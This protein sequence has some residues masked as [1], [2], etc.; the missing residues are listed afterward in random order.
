MRC[1]LCKESELTRREVSHVAD[2]DGIEFRGTIEADACPACG[3]ELASHDE[4]R[5]FDLHVADIL[6]QRAE[7]KPER[8]RFIRRALGFKGVELAR[9]LDVTPETVSRWENVSSDREMD[10][11]SFAL[12]GAMVTDAIAGRDDT[13][14]RL[15]GAMVGPS[16]VEPLRSPVRVQRSVA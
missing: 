11:R 7:R 4:L 12:L 15:E 14:R 3:E 1:P 6:A 8:V 16:K 5:R 13:R 9:L 2:V 10:P